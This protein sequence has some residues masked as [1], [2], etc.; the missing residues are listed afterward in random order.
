M[1]LARILLYDS[2][3]TIRNPRFSLGDA[4]D[5]DVN[6]LMPL[7]VRICRRFFCSPWHDSIRISRRTSREAQIVWI[8]TNI[9]AGATEI[10]ATALSS[11]LG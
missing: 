6:S 10:S 5:C 3:A 8:H 11:P 9:I 2:K 4:L 7:S 1:E